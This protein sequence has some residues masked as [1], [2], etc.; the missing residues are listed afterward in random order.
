MN[1]IRF[2][3]ALPTAL[4]MIGLTAASVSVAK[5]IATEEFE[6]GATRPVCVV[7]L[8]AEVALTKQ[9]LIRQED[10]VEESG[11]LEPY[12]TAAVADEFRSRGYA[13]SMVDAAA[14]SADATL[15]EL[16]VDVNRRF[17]ELLTNVGSRLAKS[18]NVR[19]REYNAG[20]EAR[21]L[22]A[23]VGVDAL[24]FARMEI[25][26]PAGGVRA[27]NMGV[28]G[29]T[30][31]LSV[32]VVDGTSGDIEAFITLPVTSRGKM[33]G[34]HDDIVKNPGEQMANYAG[35]TLDELPSADA[36]LRV[37]TSADDV[38]ADLDSL[39]EP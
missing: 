39:L 29:E 30:A 27:L 5:V 37:E 15:Q 20:D 31:M 26:A 10:Q 23:R 14:I 32:T 4:A 11:E 24:V 38:L 34:G 8:P 22:A 7:I 3:Q 35:G 9:K 18:K 17:D 28:G 25:I 1:E 12:L 13:V 33:F 6:N 16:V 2:R 36:S 19:A 21:L